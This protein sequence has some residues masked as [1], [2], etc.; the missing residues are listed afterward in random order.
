MK[1]TTLICVTTIALFASLLTPAR[2]FAQHTRYQLI[3]IGTFGGPAS[4][5]TDPG[6]GFGSRVL[7]NR[8]ILAGKADTSTP[9]PS[10]GNCPPICFDTRVFRW[11]NGVLTGLNGLSLTVNNSDVAAINAR[12]WIAGGSD[13]GEIDPLTGALQIHAVLWKGSDISDLG[14]LGGLESAAAYLNDAGQVVGFSTINSTPDPFSFLGGSI[15]PFIWKDGVMRDLGTLGGPDSGPS[16]GCNNERPD[17]VAGASF[18]DSTP[19]ATTGLP[20]QHAFLW[21]NGTMTE[22]PTLGGTFAT[23]QCANNQGQVIGQSNLAGDAGCNGSLDSCSQHAYSWDHGSLRD[24]GTLGGSFSVAIWVNNQGEAVGG[25]T[26]TDDESFHATLWRNG[27]ITDLGNLPDD[28]FSRAIAINSEGQ[29]A[30]QSFSCDFSS[31]RAVLWDKGSIVD[32]NTLI[33]ANSSLKLFA[34]ENINDRGEIVGRGLPAGCDDID[35][36]GHD[37]LLIPCDHAGTR[38][39]GNAGISART[40]SPAVTTSTTTP[41]QR[42]QVTKVFVAKLRARLARQYHFS[43]IGAPRK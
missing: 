27:Q 4:Y 9:E 7:H 42:G 13:T 41:A 37:F 15:H 12:G 26:T 32:L 31:I 28:C 38:C 22:I 30:G 16:G 39:E 14:T 34:A 11:Q 36:C 19:N 17:L 10:S 29:I 20:T 25:A 2:L 24:L 1:S 18:T 23:A 43:G 35:A 5:F 33:P 8:G 6:L 21:E 3:D 40:A